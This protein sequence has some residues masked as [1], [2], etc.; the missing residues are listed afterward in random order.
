MDHKPKQEQAPRP[1]RALW[2]SELAQSSLK[3]LQAMAANV[4][5]WPDYQL[6]EGPEIGTILMHGP[7]AGNGG[8][9]PVGDCTI[10]RCR[11]RDTRGYE[12]FSW[13][14]G[15]QPEIALWAARW[16]ALLQDPNHYA[17]YWKNIDQLR[18]ER[19]QREQNTATAMQKTQV[20]FFSMENMRT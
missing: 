20:R 19:M 9:F 13:I 18:Q 14:L 4:S 16:D 3:T 15:Q 8:T 11:V 2:I 6:L 7:I 5:L 17:T 12:G 1:R 10:T